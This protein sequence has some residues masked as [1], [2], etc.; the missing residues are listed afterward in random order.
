MSLSRHSFP[1]SPLLS[2][3]FLFLILSQAALAQLTSPNT[4][5]GF[6]SRSLADASP[7]R[8]SLTWNLKSHLKQSYT[9]WPLLVHSGAIAATWLLIVSETDAGIERWANRQNETISAIIS[10]PPLIAGFVVPALVPLWMIR[11]DDMRIRN[12]GIAVGQAVGITFAMVNILKA[13]TG[14]IPPDRIPPE[15]MVERSRVFNW[16]FLREGVFTGWPSGHTITNM[17]MAS[18]LANYF[19]DNRTVKITSYGWA[20]YVA[21]AATYGVQGGVHWLSDVVA[22]GMMGWIIGRTI[23]KSFA[24]RDNEPSTSSVVFQPVYQ[25]HTQALH[26]SIRFAF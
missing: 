19:H 13:V 14:R 7:E 5:R 3:A 17:A 15:D 1:S 4:D 23:G 18:A 9:G 24:Q 22:G 20:F 2:I 25:P 16:G 11:S 12:G 10:A 6:V 8:L 26:L 21:F